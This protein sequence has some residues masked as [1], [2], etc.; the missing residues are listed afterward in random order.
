L[1]TKDIAYERDG[2]A[3]TGY[4]ADGA[5]STATK[6]NTRTSDVAMRTHDAG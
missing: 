1:N 4:L 3:L 2:K 6:K 5:P